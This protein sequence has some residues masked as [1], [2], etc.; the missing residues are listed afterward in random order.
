MSKPKK[1]APDNQG[2]WRLARETRKK[3]EKWPEWKR[4]I[5]IQLTEY[6]TGPRKESGAN[7]DAR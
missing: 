4:N 1:N 7:V 2:Y 3:I 6:S 5:R